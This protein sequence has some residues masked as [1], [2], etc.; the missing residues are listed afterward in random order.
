MKHVFD[1]FFFR[2]S[3]LLSGHSF[4]LRDVEGHIKRPQGGF[5]LVEILLVIAVSSVLLASGL[6]FL[7]PTYQL[8]RGNDAKRKADLLTLQSGLERFFADAGDYPGSVGWCAQISSVAYPQVKQ[9]LSNYITKVP[10]DPVYAG[11][12]KDYY[13]WHYEDGQYRLY[14]VLD[15]TND[16]V[17]IPQ[18]LNADG[19]IP[20]CTDA[21]LSYNYRN[22]SSSPLGPTS[23][24][25]P[26][27]NTPTNTPTPTPKAVYVDSTSSSG[28]ESS[29]ASVSWSHAI[30]GINRLLLV[31]V[32]TEISRTVTASWTPASTGIAESLAHVTSSP[33][34]TSG[35]KYAYLLYRK[36]PTSGT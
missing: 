25:L 6:S 36:N 19:G 12:T 26:P 23:T 11:T 5:T 13:Y 8:N 7:N 18:V 16:P 1:L 35:D 34:G 33:Q 32:V 28:A 14:A 22:D 10:Q 30:N 20:G 4:T 2:G 27:T 3:S 31:G 24:P 15:N 21:N 29:L 9:A 17:V